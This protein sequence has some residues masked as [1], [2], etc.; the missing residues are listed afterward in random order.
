MSE[1]KS[2]YPRDRDSDEDSDDDDDEQVEEE[3]EEE[4]EYYQK[5]IKEQTNPFNR[6]LLDFVENKVLKGELDWNKADEIFA[7]Y[8]ALREQSELNGQTVLHMLID[9]W[10]KHIPVNLKVLPPIRKAFVAIVAKYP[11]LVKVRDTL[12]QQGSRISGQTVL[13]RAIA[14][15]HSRIVDAV[16]K[17][18]KP[19]ETTSSSGKK[20]K[21]EKANDPLSQAIL[22]RCSAD[23]RE[24]NSLHFALRSSP[25]VVSPETLKKLVRKSTEAAVA[26]ADSF[27][28]TPLHYAV[29]YS[30]CSH[31]QY[32]IIKSLLKTGEKSSLIKSGKAVLD[33]VTN[34]ERLSVYRYHIK[35]REQ[36][37]EKAP[38][39][40]LGQSTRAKTEEDLRNLRRQD[41]EQRAKEFDE[42]RRRQQRQQQG[43]RKRAQT[44]G[45]RD[46]ES[47]GEANK[48]SHFSRNAQPAVPGKGAPKGEDAK[49]QVYKGAPTGSGKEF[50]DKE[51]PRGREP[52]VDTRAPPAARD[53][54]QKPKGDGRP[55]GPDPRTPLK[56]TATVT[57]AEPESEE[58]AEDRKRKRDEYSDKLKMDIKIQYLRTRSHHKAVKFLYGKNPDGMHPR[59]L[60]T[61]Q[62]TLSRY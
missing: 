62:D 16:V 5:Q 39:P 35:T 30:R 6:A 32:G 2:P 42:Q 3:D 27:G 21:K 12:D 10:Q 49:S 41:E 56:R 45:D 9:S 19:I 44:D 18:T 38:P 29:D 57:F 51:G 40:K 20:S 14:S 61:Y 26:A 25:Q 55:R 11:E 15:G 17:N 59:Y 4:Q 33:F 52:R 53:E 34:G 22:V 48:A 60:D 1:P 31:D 58:T 43:E 37:R 23:G 7:L 47:E 13:Y 54:S 8:P 28:F 24:E 36:F 50:R 46:S